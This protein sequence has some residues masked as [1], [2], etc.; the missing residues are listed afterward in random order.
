M[1]F[2]PN[3]PLSA[4]TG[5]ATALPRAPSS[6][7]LEPLRQI[8]AGVLNI[9]YYEEGPADGPA[10]LLLHGFPF[11]I[12][13]YVDVAPQLAASGCRVIA[14]ALTGHPARGTPS[15]GAQGIHGGGDGIDQ[16]ITKRRRDI[17]D[18][19]RADLPWASISLTAFL[20]KETKVSAPSQ[21][22]S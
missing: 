7:R 6:R 22:P 4:Q 13:S 18:S 19:S 2:S 5:R 1:E 14:A 21:L 8:E 12:H 9:A 20:S 16:G 10:V 3:R 17:Y 11:D 15:G